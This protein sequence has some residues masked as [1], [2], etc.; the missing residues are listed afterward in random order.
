MAVLSALEDPVVGGEG[1]RELA[2]ELG[3][4]GGSCRA[5]EPGAP[6]ACVFAPPLGGHIAFDVVSLSSYHAFLETYFSFGQ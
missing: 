6:P 3:R 2:A 5:G 4:Q 1:V